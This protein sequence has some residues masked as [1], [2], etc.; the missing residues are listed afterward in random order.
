[1]DTTQHFPGITFASYLLYVVSLCTVAR[2]A[3]TSDGLQGEVVYPVGSA[4]VVY[5]HKRHQ[6]RW[7]CRHLTPIT[8]MAAHPHANIMATAE[9]LPQPCIHVWAVDP[10]PSAIKV[11]AVLQVGGSMLLPS[12]LQPHATSFALFPVTAV[13]L[14]DPRSPSFVVFTFRRGIGCH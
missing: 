3:T 2:G 1:M 6:Q 4:A 8:A 12:A 14:N 11:V 10:S 5:H 7:Y 13:P 9:D